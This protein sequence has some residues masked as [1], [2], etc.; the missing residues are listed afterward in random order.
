[1]E[2]YLTSSPVIYETRAANPAN[3]FLRSLRHSLEG[4]ASALFVCSDPDGHEH[5]DRFADE[6]WQVLAGE[7]IAFSSRAVLDGR[8]EREAAALVK[9]ADFLVLA[10]GH[11]PTQ[12]AFF[13]RIGLRELLRGWDGVLMGISAGTMNSAD[14]VYS[15]PELSGEAA[16]PNYRRFLPGLGL[17]KTMILP[18]L[19]ALRYEVLDGLRSYEDIAFPDSAGRVFYAL[20]DGSYLYGRNGR[21]ELRGE[22]WRIA[23]GTMEKLLD[24]GEILPL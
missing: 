21:E 1:M 22:A 7:G 3:G 2:L 10:G 5:T 19:Q 20:P 4:A 18:H 24:D 23:D 14:T 6:I 12:N 15:Q 13:Q 16:D 17:T 8:N 11:V 9:G